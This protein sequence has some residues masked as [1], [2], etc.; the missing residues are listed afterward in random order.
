MDLP[1]YY[2]GPKH[3]WS[4]AAAMRAQRTIPA[5]K[6]CEL[7]P[8]ASAEALFEQMS[9]N[10]DC[11]S[12]I[13]TYNLEQG[14]VYDF[15][16]FQLFEE[17]GDIELKTR[18][19]VFGQQERL[20]E[21]ERIYT[22]DTVVPQVSHWIEELP[23]S[24]EIIARPDISTARGVQ[25]AAAEKYAA[26]ICSEAAGRAYNLRPLALD[27]AN[28]KDNYTAFSVFTQG[29]WF[30]PNQKLFSKPVYEFGVTDELAERAK[31]GQ[32]N[33][34]WHLSSRNNA[35]LHLGH[36]SAILTLL[37]L[38]DWGNRLTIQ[39]EDGENFAALEAQL[40][41]VFMGYA[42]SSQ[43]AT[44]R[45]KIF[46]PS[47]VRSQIK[48]L[49]EKRANIAG[50]SRVEGREL[51][52]LKLFCN[53]QV[54]LHELAETQADLVV[55]GPSLLPDLK[56]IAAELEQIVPTLLVDYLPGTDNYAKMTAGKQNQINWP[57]EQSPLPLPKRMTDI[58]FAAERLEKFQIYA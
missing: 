19:C 42:Y 14:I 23:D 10:A 17:V 44:D 13:P 12:I 26:A 45:G 58:H 46:N 18:M 37:K 40:D 1:L 36:I 57:A 33:I 34:L 55:A 53:H 30:R 6:S 4:H 15:A 21:I 27:I 41:Q 43:T 48:S 3:T 16:R 47:G 29:K 49:L 7:I 28:N 56:M 54:L 22:K 35:Q 11:Y 9:T 39:I 50:C 38:A 20:S 5:L 25:M 32:L 31:A 52:R 24:I 51:E 8:L 2:L